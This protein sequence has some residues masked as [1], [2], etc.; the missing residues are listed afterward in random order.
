MIYIYLPYVPIAPIGGVQTLFDY[1]ERLNE[2]AQTTVATIVSP[3]RYIRS[4]L[5]RP[6]PLVSVLHTSPKLTSTDILLFPEVLLAN[7]NNYPKENKKYLVVLN[8]KYLDIAMRNRSALPDITGIIT[9]CHFTANQINKNYP[10]VPTIAIPH[11]IDPLFK[12]HIP[13]KKRPSDSILLMNRKN[14]HHIPGILEFLEQSHHQVTLINNVPP[15][16][17]V[18]QYNNHRIFI[19][20]GYPEGFCRPAAEAMA[21]GCVVV[22]FTGGGGSDFMKHRKN[23][24]IAPDGDEKEL[25]RLLHFV[26]NEA[27]I[28]EL[29]DITTQ[30]KDII[31]TG[32]TDETQAW[33]LYK[34]F[35]SQI[36]VTYTKQSIHALYAHTKK[37]HKKSG[38]KP[39]YTRMGKNALELQL[40]YERQKY[41][42]LTSSKFFVLWQKY[43][44]ARSGL[45]KTLAS[46]KERSLEFLKT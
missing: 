8:W 44:S 31:R 26:L 46:W 38:H 4:I 20:L 41:K 34:L 5:P 12:E 36:P 24:F 28:E 7:I 32:Y 23:C 21:S 2:L 27:S 18:K 11:T 9:N 42:E 39:L 45:T 6:Y 22:G 19:N 29:T 43:C 14:T 30:A 3:A 17:L 16:Q 37:K 15:Q 10:S 13:Y 25:I 40:Y 33:A 1:A 35:S